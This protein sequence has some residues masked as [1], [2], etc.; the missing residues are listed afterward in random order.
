MIEIENKGQFNDH[1]KEDVATLHRIYE[2]WQF[3][4]FAPKGM[5]NVLE[6][7]LDVKFE[8]NELIK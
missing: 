6:L 8:F 3:A 2:K 4:N 1:L 5:D 7:L